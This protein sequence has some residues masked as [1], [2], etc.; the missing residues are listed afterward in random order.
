MQQT[1]I[2]QKAEV[3]CTHSQEQESGHAELGFILTF[4]FLIYALNQK[5]NRSVNFTWEF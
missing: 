3:H 1:G 5:G 4:V 2:Q